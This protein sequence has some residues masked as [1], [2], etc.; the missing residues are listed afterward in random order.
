[1]NSK[2][3]R[4]SKTQ[5]IFGNR[6]YLLTFAAV[7]QRKWRDAVFRCSRSAAYPPMV[8]APLRIASCLQGF[9]ERRTVTWTMK[10][11]LDWSN[12]PSFAPCCATKPRSMI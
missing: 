5:S 1:M 2:F 7:C 9:A 4:F 3:H 8:S 11:K 12:S 10:A 6:N